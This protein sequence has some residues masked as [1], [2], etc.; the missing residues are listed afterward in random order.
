MNF[1]V[2]YCHSHE[3]GNPFFAY[4]STVDIRFR[5]YDIYYLLS[6][7]TSVN[8][9]TWTDTY[10][11]FIPFFSQF[12]YTAGDADLV[13]KAVPVIIKANFVLYLKQQSRIT[14]GL[15]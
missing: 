6:C 15:L 10:K 5:G 7:V 13:G 4:F 12:L 1:K 3:S 14:A 2:L 11:Y 9:R 8:N